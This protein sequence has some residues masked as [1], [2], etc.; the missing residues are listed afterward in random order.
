MKKARLRPI[1]DKRRRRIDERRTTREAVLYR[2]K[3]MCEMRLAGCF[4]TATEVHEILTRARGGSIYDP[5]N[6]LAACSS[7]HRWV[8]EHPLEAEELGLVIH[9]WG[10]LDAAQLR[11][12]DQGL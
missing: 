2:A 1:S 10:C 7:C 9:S 4:G 6:C 8:T 12:R 5:E 3:G 11:R